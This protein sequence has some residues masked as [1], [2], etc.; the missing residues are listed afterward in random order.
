M[1]KITTYLRRDILIN[2]NDVE[3]LGFPATRTVGEMIDLA[4]QHGCKLIVKNGKNGKWYLKGKT[5]SIDYLKEK[6]TSPTLQEK[7]E[8][9]YCL[10]IE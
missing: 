8:G 1:P 3:D 9:V 6:L 5:R 7:R 10:L 4:I 2:K